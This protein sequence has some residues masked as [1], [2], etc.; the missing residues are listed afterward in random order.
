VT[1][2]LSSSASASLIEELEDVV[3]RLEVA[4]IPSDHA[5]A[6]AEAT[7]ILRAQQRLNVIGLSRISDVNARGLHEQEGFRSARSWLRE[8]RPDGDT[9]D[10]WLGSS[11]REFPVLG[12]AVSSGAC[13]MAAASKVVQVL[14][15]ARR[16]V[17][18]GDGLI[19]GFPAA[20]VMPAVV[21][22]VVTLV[23]RYLH[24][25]VD[26]DPRLASLVAA[27]EAI[28]EGGGSE[29]FQFEAACTL[30]ASEVPTRM[31]TPL[32]R[33]L[34]VSLVPSLLEADGEAARDKA[35]LELI[36]R[37]DGTWHVSG[38]LDTECGERL[39]VALRSESSRDPVNP[40]DT[41]LWVQNR[42]A[43]LQPWDDGAEVIRPR[44][45]RRRLH[46]ALDR[47]LE[48]YLEA[49]LG[50]VSGKVPVQ[51]NVLVPCPG[52]GVLPAVGDSGALI[53]R[54][55]VR[56]WWC[57][58]SVTAFVM[59]LG[60]KALRVIHGQRTLTA[61]ERR[62]LYLETGGQC[63]ALDC[64]STHPDPL[65]EVVPHHA[66]RWADCGRTTLDETVLLC[67]HDHRDLH[68]GKTILLRDGRYLTE[69]GVS[70]HPPP[71]EPPPF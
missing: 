58:S 46:D 31:L 19:D 43:G 18:V 51:L 39:F 47:L 23:S 59:S 55:L 12:E 14:R 57:D 49:G 33:E 10:V 66:K 32:L 7:R 25:L 41:A 61:R 2:V 37:P 62:A 13:A 6:F 64:T 29:L 50:G 30:L 54:A 68:E 69:Q 3:A 67:K 44:D 21:R 28:V 4:G 22:N 42:D 20:E 34:L 11:L 9:S 24:G 63:A 15:L 48:R 16:H 45:R 38:D 40:A 35:G 70:D 5:S 36:R 60:G 8:V 65:L 17:D 53:P 1:A 52:P 56:R 71:A 26:D 27:A